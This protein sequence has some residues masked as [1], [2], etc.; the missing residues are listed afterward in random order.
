MMHRRRNP[1]RHNRKCHSG[2]TPAKPPHSFSGIRCPGSASC[3]PI[4]ITNMM[5]DALVSSG[6]PLSLSRRRSL[7]SM[8][9]PRPKN[10]RLTA[11]WQC[12]W[13]SAGAKTRPARHLTAPA[14]LVIIFGSLT[15]SAPNRW[16]SV[17]A[18]NWTVLSSGLF[19][20]KRLASG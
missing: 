2:L 16:P 6:I 19:W 20:G 3:K 17:S 18:T 12:E 5:D 4:P 11:Y 8:S 14:R 10:S 15:G 7:L 1:L 13:F 9:A